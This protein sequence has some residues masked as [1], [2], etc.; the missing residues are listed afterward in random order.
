MANKQDDLTGV[1]GEGVSL[2][3]IKAVDEAFGALLG[4]R[5]SRM[6]YA[7]KEKEA[8]AEL[9]ALMEKHNLSIYNYDDRVYVLADIKKVKLKPK[10]EDDGE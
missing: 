1:E 10:D 4:A 7:T 9:I 5:G 8:Q 6:K 3:K 2:K